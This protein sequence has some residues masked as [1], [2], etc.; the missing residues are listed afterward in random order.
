MSSCHCEQ[1]IQAYV[2][3]DPASPQPAQQS[4]DKAKDS[5]ISNVSK[6]WSSQSEETLDA[7]KNV[8]IRPV[9][10]S[11]YQ[12]PSVENCQDES[13]SEKLPRLLSYSLAF[14]EPTSRPE[15]TDM[16]W[17]RPRDSSPMDDGKAEK[18]G[19]DVVPPAE[20]SLEEL[21]EESP[22]PDTRP[23]SALRAD[24]I[25]PR[26]FPAIDQN[27]PEGALPKDKKESSE[28]YGELDI[29]DFEHGDPYA[30]VE[31]SAGNEHINSY[32]RA[33]YTYWE[34]NRTLGHRSRC[35]TCRRSLPRTKMPVNAGVPFWI[36]W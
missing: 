34:E 29:L 30:P 21:S 11:A 7:S 25:P 12:M 36:R 23:G 16:P 20:D 17:K 33:T 24:E 6:A 28:S 3:I 13:D 4:S 8:T 5:W 22:E 10:S 19:P 1:F 31:D 18:L 9:K 2:Y 35:P 15:S 26:A 14:I 27:S 32:H